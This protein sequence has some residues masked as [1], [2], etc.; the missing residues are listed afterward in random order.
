M[1][2]TWMLALILS[3][4][5]AACGEDTAAPKKGA[6]PAS[7]V[8][9]TTASERV[10]SQR[11]KI[12]AEL[13]ALEQ[14]TIVSETSGRI[15]KLHADVG[16]KVRAGELLAEIDAEHLD[17]EQSAKN[18]DLAKWRTQRDQKAR[19]LQRFTE[20]QKQGFVTP[21]YLENLRAELN[22]LDR[23]LTAAN[24]VASNAAREVG[25]AEI[26]APIDGTI[27][28]RSANLGEFVNVG[29]TLFVLSGSQGLRAKFAVSEADAAAL[30]LGA[31]V[32]LNGRQ[33]PLNVRV[34]EVRPALNPQNRMLEAWATLPVVHEFLPGQSVEGEVI[35][36]QRSV[37]A[38][39]AAAIVQREMGS[40]V[41]LAKDGKAVMQVVQT[42]VLDG[43]WMEV[44]SGVKA[45][46]VVVLEGA[47]FLT[48]GA[49]I[50]DAAA[51][52]DKKNAT[53]A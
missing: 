46:D 10:L 19:D 48:D 42:G 38:L 39:P 20:L 29:K 51:K 41:F 5:L 2:K 25:K 13:Q 14:P 24:A 11:V 16:Q 52:K 12:L 44:V 53:K 27:D 33:A 15:L 8:T 31:S 9:L 7:S 40:V 18:A 1:M 22:A 47:G 26:R 36:S 23:Q 45:G 3:L 30:Q 21:S 37:L 6:P 35:L 17:N 50:R 49:A 4:A 43:A 28:A 32:T 34:T